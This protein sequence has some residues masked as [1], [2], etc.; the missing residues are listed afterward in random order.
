MDTD[1]CSTSALTKN[2][3]SRGVTAKKGYVLVY[4]AHC[5]TLVFDTI[6]SNAAPLV[7]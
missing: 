2:H 1:T 6:I 5:L 4:P 7:S 3:H